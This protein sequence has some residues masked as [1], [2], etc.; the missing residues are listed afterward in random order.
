MSSGFDS[1]LLPDERDSQTVCGNASHVLAGMI[2]ASV[3]LMPNSANLPAT[4]ARLLMPLFAASISSWLALPSA[5]LEARSLTCAPQHGGLSLVTRHV[6][7]FP[8][9]LLF[10]P[11]VEVIHVST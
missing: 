11:V 7:E 8:P 3:R 10:S 6:P 2:S 1:K 5:A 9:A 4:N